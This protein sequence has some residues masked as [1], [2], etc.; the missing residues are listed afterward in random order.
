M[1]SMTCLPCSFILNGLLII[2]LEHGAGHLES[3][4]TADLRTEKLKLPA[5]EIVKR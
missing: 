1:K 4:K 5:L 3:I 2:H